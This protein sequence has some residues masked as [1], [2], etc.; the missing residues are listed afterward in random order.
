MVLG[1]GDAGQ[2]LA[3]TFLLL[4]HSGAQNRLERV[5]IVA[6][7]LMTY[8]IPI[9]IGNG[10][11]GMHVLIA[12]LGGMI[13]VSDA[14]KVNWRIELTVAILWLFALTKPNVSVP[15]FWLALFVPRAWRLM[16]LVGAGYVALTIFAAAFQPVDLPDLLIEMFKV[17]E[18]AITQNSG[19]HIPFWFSLLGWQSYSTLATLAFFV[20]LGAWVYWNCRADVW[21]LLGVAGIVARVWTYH[22]MYD[23][24]LILPAMIA[25]F[26]IVKRG[27]AADGSDVV[28]GFIWRML[29]IASCAGSMVYHPYPW[30]LPYHVGNP[31]IWF[32]T[33]FYLT[34]YARG[35]AYRRETKCLPVL[36]LLFQHLIDHVN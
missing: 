32:A 7:L 3:L 9:T 5:L 19:A 15:F 28:A 29:A 21:F 33:L 27:V 11:L 4:K 36:Q 31:I 25:L 13:L 23:D 20:L 8:P 1:S 14:R 26:R 12:F 16:I 22:R 10:Q 24:L 35:T 2:L 18:Q 30:N 6:T 34:M 17:S